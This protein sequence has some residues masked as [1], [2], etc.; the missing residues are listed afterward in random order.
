MIRAENGDE[1]AEVER[2]N[3]VAIGWPQVG[4]LSDL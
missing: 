1:L 3:L 2:Q 4:V